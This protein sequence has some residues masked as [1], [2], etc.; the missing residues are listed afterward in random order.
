MKNHITILFAVLFIL[1]HS[2][3]QVN[4]DMK[5]DTL[6]NYNDKGKK[7]GY[8]LE[9]FNEKLR[10]TKKEKKAFY[11]GVCYYGAKGR[12][13]PN[14][15]VMSPVKKY[16][17]ITN[18]K[19]GIKGI[20]ILLD[21]NYYTIYKEDTIE[22]VLFKNGNLQLINSYYG[23]KKIH[24]YFDYRKKYKEDKL[25]HYLVEYDLEGKIKIKGYFTRIDDTWRFISDDVEK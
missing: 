12:I 6:N 7:H 11:Y 13:Y 20:P 18:G 4:H 19:T 21:G 10:I 15:G 5:N 3:G 25:S 23:N 14:Y 9:Y 22:D 17:I 24:Y 1:N 16:H 2:Y 8:W